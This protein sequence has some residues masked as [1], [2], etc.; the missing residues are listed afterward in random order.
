M[1]SLMDGLDEVVAAQLQG[2]LSCVPEIASRLVTVNLYG[3]IFEKD[4]DVTEVIDA[5]NRALSRSEN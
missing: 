3:A 5:I 2:V 1:T 4:V